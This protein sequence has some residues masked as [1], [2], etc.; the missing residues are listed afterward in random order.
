MK[1]IVSFIVITLLC[2]ALMACNK[3]D[4]LVL[5]S[6]NTITLNYGDPLPNDPSAFL[7]VSNLSQ[8]EIAAIQINVVKPVLNEDGQIDLNSSLPFDEHNFGE[9]ALVFSLDDEQAH[10]YMNYVDDE[11]PILSLVRPLELNRGQRVD[12]NTYFE[13]TNDKDVTLVFDD[14]EVNY[15]AAGS[16]ILHVTATD[17]KGNQSVEDFELVIKESA[18]SN[19][20]IDDEGYETSNDHVYKDEEARIMSELS[21]YRSSNNLNQLR[22]TEDLDA[23]A[24]STASAYASGQE[25]NLASKTIYA[26]GTGA[27]VDYLG[28][29]INNVSTKAVLD[30][31]S[32]SETG[33]AIVKGEDNY[34]AVIAFN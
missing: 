1:K 30:D 29:W 14:S 26:Y 2:L 13:V 33:I 16:Y 18:Q 5:L 24:L 8:E 19:E 10:I 22:R 32:L 34:Y 23:L 3:E 25:P 6:N 21:S 11:A 17:S 12:F 31:N 27:G 28:I 20:V 4:R 7:D 9:Y 15:Y